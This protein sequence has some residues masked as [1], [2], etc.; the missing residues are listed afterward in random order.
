MKTGAE[1][2]KVSLDGL[3]TKFKD[4]HIA[5]Q[6]FS[7]FVI[8][9]MASLAANYIPGVNDQLSQTIGL[10]AGLGSFGYNIGGQIAS[11]FGKNS[12]IGS[13]IGTSISIAIGFA[14]SAYNDLENKA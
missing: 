14:I 2:V 5:S 12:G 1:K 6:A 7:S 9:T 11:A 4:V 13:A 3:K 10:L 8:G